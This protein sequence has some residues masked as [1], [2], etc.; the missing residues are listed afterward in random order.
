MV[1]K[2][3]KALK[4]SYVNK[5]NE[6]LKDQKVLIHRLSY[7]AGNRQ[8]QNH[9]LKLKSDNAKKFRPFLISVDSETWG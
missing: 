8:N 2:R 9:R 5:K 7:R 6:N 1:R 3:V 4:L